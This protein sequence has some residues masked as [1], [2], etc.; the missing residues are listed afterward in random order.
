M[1]RMEAQGVQSELRW[2]LTQVGSPDDGGAGV[3]EGSSVTV[4]NGGAIGQGRS[5]DDGGGGVSMGGVCNGGTGVGHGGSSV[6]QRGGVGHGSVSGG[7]DGQDGEEGDLRKC[8]NLMH[9][10]QQTEK[11]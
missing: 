5:T 4:G 6:G 9:A 11:V 2:F 1:G 8:K 7:G 10:T 3:G